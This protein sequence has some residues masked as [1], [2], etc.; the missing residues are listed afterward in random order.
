MRKVSNPIIRGFYPDPSICRVGADYYLV[1]SSFAYFPGIPVFHSRDLEHWNQIGNA[2]DR[3]SQVDLSDCLVSQ[4]IYAPTIRYHK[5]LFYIITTKV[6]TGGN[7]IIT[8]KDPAGPWSDAYMLGE[9]A[10]GIDPSLFFDEDD[11]CY[12]IGTRP[13]SEGEAYFGNWEIYL[14]EL[15]LKKMKLIGQCKSVWQGAMRNAYWP[16][17][18]HLYKKDGY[19]YILTAEG[20]TER[21]HSIMISRS[22]TLW[23]PYEGAPQ[24]PILTHRH[25]GNDF[26]VQCVGHG[27]F[28]HTPENDWYIVMLGMRPCKGYTSLGRETFL[29]KVEWENDWPVVNKGIGRLEE[30]VI[31][32]DSTDKE[33]K[34][35][36]KNVYGFRDGLLTYNVISLRG[37][38]CAADSTARSGWLRL[39][40]KSESF[41]TTCPISLI[42]VRQKDYHYSVRTKME[43]EP[44]TLHDKAGMVL[45]QNE[46]SNLTIYKKYHSDGN[47]LTVE[48]NIGVQNSVIAQVMVHQ[49][50]LE[51]KFVARDQ[52][53]ELLFRYEGDKDFYLLAENIDLRSYSTEAAGGF[54]GCILGVFVFGNHNVSADFKYLIY[55]AF[56]I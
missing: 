4:G 43:F 46:E 47:L 40:A 19:Y 52:K 25:L 15:D 18:P 49:D 33:P 11:R 12:F 54:T 14:Q 53:G 5:G 2:L 7:F 29:A 22:K 56:A 8:A 13:N 16:E 28:F 39:H 1:N 30:N 41:L 26:P 20:G 24:N 35:I 17:G 27:D 42:G 55:E 50:I 23:G 9:T 37:G 34:S 48:S 51:I 3:V 32:P 44:R 38:L 45:F 36:E 6:P 10:P 21:N 31:L